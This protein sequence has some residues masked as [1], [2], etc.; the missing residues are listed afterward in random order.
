MLGVRSRLAVAG[1]LLG[2]E[3]AALAIAYQVFTTVSCE[4]TGTAAICVFLG[5]FVARGLAMAAAFLLV[6]WARPEATRGLL[7]EMA[8][9]HDRWP[10]FWLHI[11]GIAVLLAPIALAGDG[12]WSAVFAHA[13]VPLIGGAG[14]AAVGA[15]L[16]LAPLRAWGDW[17]RGIGPAAIGA[18]ALAFL[19]PDLAKVSRPLWDLSLPAR[20]TFEAVHLVLTLA[21]TAPEV[22]PDERVVGTSGFYVEIANACSGVEGFALFLGL[23]VIYSVLFRSSLRFGRFWLVLVPIGL[24][25]SWTL[26]VLRI[27][28]LV[29]IGAYVSP[30]LAANGF[31]S[32]AGWMLFTLLAV[33]LLCAAHAID[34][35]H[36]SETAPARHPWLTD[37]AAAAILP[38]A[39]LMLAET[40]VR[41]AFAQPALAYP[42]KIAVPAAILL[43]FHAA[44]RPLARR[45]DAVSVAAGAAVG[46]LWIAVQPEASA[47]DSALVADLAGLGGVAL[48]AWAVARVAGTVLV[49]PLVEELF[50]RGYLLGRLDGGGPVARVLAI[51]VSSG[52][53][54][55]MHERWLVAFVAG[56]VFALVALRRGRLADAI[57]AHVAANAVV[58]GWAAATGDWTAI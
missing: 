40:A 45:P 43:V 42:L 31:H 36:R 25:L 2:L 56:V 17:L 51:A 46:L 5:S 41:A 32:Y 27:S 54:A 33:A 18:L 7:A 13:L 57:A 19:L 23:S 38:F 58:A 20:A 21:G 9:D 4:A 6:L 44:Y 50:F 52:A 8:L 1:A 29:L 30:G 49:V 22:W 35:L 55:L 53:F 28:A 37:R 10:W 24:A 48:A 47:A 39:G 14:A 12:D 16:W 26:N 34:W 11:A 3:L 15:L